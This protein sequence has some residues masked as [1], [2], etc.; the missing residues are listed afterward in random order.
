[1][2]DMA[3]SLDHIAISTASERGVHERGG[4]AGAEVASTHESRASGAEDDDGGWGTS[5]AELE[6][7]AG[8]SEEAQG[9]P[10][11]PPGR[12]GKAPDRIT[13]SEVDEQSEIEAVDRV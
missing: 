13:S 12:G 7:E 2:P 1:M 10:E 5:S 11:S 3:R 4:V 8:D 6:R 9:T